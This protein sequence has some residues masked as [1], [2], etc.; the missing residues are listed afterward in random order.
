MCLLYHTRTLKLWAIARKMAIKGKNYEF[1]DKAQITSAT[2]TSLWNRSETP[3]LWEIADKKIHKTHKWWVFWYGSKTCTDWEWPYKSLWILKILGNS[4]QKGHKTCKRWVF[5]HDSKNCIDCHVPKLWAIAHKNSCKTWIY[6]FL[7]TALKND[8]TV[9]C[10]VNRPRTP[11][12]WSIAH[13]NGHNTRKRWVVGHGAKKGIDYYVPSISHQNPKIVGNSSQNGHQTRK[14]HFFGQ[15]SNNISNC[16][17]PLK[18]LRDIKT[19][20]DSSQKISI[21]LVNDKFFDMALKPA[22]T[23]KG[24]VN[25][26]EYWKLWA[27][28]QKRP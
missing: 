28:A 6:Q 5:G 7:D 16:H 27:I 4:S 10:H 21:K 13:E 15:G 25:R 17:E 11:K 19:V 18:L 20:G 1:L 23:M 22:L 26:S 3:K 2:V 12:L 8:P 9:T 14:R 24:P